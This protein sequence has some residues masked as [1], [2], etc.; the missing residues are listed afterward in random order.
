MSNNKTKQIAGKIEAPIKLNTNWS[1]PYYRIKI[2]QVLKE[3]NR[4]NKVS[5]INGANITI[6]NLFNTVSISSSK[7]Y[8]IDYNGIDNY[9]DIRSV[10]KSDNVINPLES[11]KTYLIYTVPSRE[12]P[13]YNTLELDNNNL[14]NFLF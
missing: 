3:L 5:L 10:P 7:F 2:G 8:Y 12:F 1:S 4:Q 14:Y 6:D 9:R 13:I 11:N